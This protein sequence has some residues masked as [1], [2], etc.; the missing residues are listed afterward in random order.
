MV[1]LAA[2]SLTEVL[3]EAGA[4]WA[5]KGHPA[6]A[7]SFDASSK[8][9]KQIE[10][11]AP[12]DLYLS[13]DQQWMDHLDGRGL[14]A[15]G[16]RVDLVGNTLV[17]VVPAA[18]APGPAG[19]EDLARPSVRRLGLAGENVP[20]G[21]YGRASLRSLGLWD[22]L[23]E[24]VVSGDNV[25]TVLGWVAT[26]EVDA[27]LVYATDAPVEPRVRVAFRLPASSHPPIVY[28]AAVVKG[29]PHPR[30]AEAFLAFCEGSEGRTIFAAAGFPPPPGAP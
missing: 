23:A 13:A 22:T 7:F 8:L 26:G 29:A 9:A 28:P 10:A 14:L 27:G 24:R 18:S 12:A 3:Q 30:E 6:P 16:T 20:A 21:R 4:V 17:V 5:A 19:P 15:P 2:A 25:R 1:V 11:G